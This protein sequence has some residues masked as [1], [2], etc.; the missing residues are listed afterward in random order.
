LPIISQHTQVRN[1]GYFRLEWKLA[2]E[3]THLFAEGV[4]FIAPVVVGDTTE[5]GAVVPPEFMQRPA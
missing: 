2:V 1:K 4:P 5:A 3:Q